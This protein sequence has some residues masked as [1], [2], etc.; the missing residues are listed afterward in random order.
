MIYNKNENNKRTFYINYFISFLISL[1]QLFFSPILP[2][3]IL[4]ITFSFFLIQ[5]LPLAIQLPYKTVA[6]FR[7]HLGKYS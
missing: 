1:L 5:P 7:Q 4:L 2:F 6:K 3:P